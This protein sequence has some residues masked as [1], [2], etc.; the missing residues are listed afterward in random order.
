MKNRLFIPVLFSVLLA[1]V[2]S[3]RLHAEEQD[4]NDFISQIQTS[5]THKDIAAYLENFARDI[6]SSEE[7]SFKDKFDIFKMERASLFKTGESVQSEDNAEVFLQALFQNSYSAL[8]ETWHLKL[9]RMNDQWQITDK[10]VAGNISS[11]YRIQIPSNSAERVESVEVEHEDIKLTFKDAWLFSDNIPNLET[12][13]LIIGKGN[14]YFSPSDPIEKHQLKL[15]Y[16]KEF[17]DDKLTYAFLRFS[18]SYFHNHIKIER[19]PEW[20][21]AKPSQEDRDAAQSIFSKHYPRSFTVEYSLNREL[22]STLPQ[23][24][25]AV[26]DFRGEKHGTFTYVYSPFTDE[27]INLYRWKD[28]QIINLYSPKS[29]G[30]QKELFLSFGQMFEV[31]SYQIEVDFRPEQYFLSGK[32]RIEVESYVESL[33]KLKFKLNP[34]LNILRIQ[35]EEGRTLFYSQDKLRETLYVYFIHSPPKNKPYSI[36]VFY[37][38]K[39]M[40]PV[41]ISDA[42]ADPQIIRRGDPGRKLSVIDVKYETYL[43]SQRASWYPSPAESDY[44]QARVKI[45]VPAEFQCISNGEMIETFFLNKTERVRE[46]DE[47]ENAVFIFDVKYPVKYLSM[48]IGKFTNVEEDH[49]SLPLQHFYSSGVLFEKK[50]LLREAKNIVEFFEEK[51]GAYPYEKLDIVRRLWTTYGGHSPAS[52]IIINELFQTPDGPL[53]VPVRSPVDLSRW[54][55]YFIA[56][57]ISHQWWGQAV[58]WKTYHDLWLSEGLA[59][60]SA[61]LYLSE[62]HGKEVLEPIFGKFTHWTEKMTK[63]GPVSLGARLAL[64]DPMAFQTVVYNK[65]A[66]A[67]NMLKDLLGEEMF[68]DGLNRFYLRHK[69]GRASTADFI[70]AMEDASGKSLRTFFKNWFGS[71]TLPGVKVSHSLHKSSNGYILK[72]KIDQMKDVFVFPLWIEWRENGNSV[73]RMVVVDERNEEFD[74]ELRVKPQKIEVNPDN[75]VPGKFH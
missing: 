71:Y 64:H 19:S 31:K 54:R 22:F 72:F 3:P 46:E 67:L 14:L 70:K 6:R 65:A 41:E 24:D 27:E 35:D 29:D 51:F 18:N 40:P 66:L 10:N 74:I 8:I 5:L 55:E 68:F 32:A 52:F 43:F 38:G 20:K 57:E 12:A 7:K 44:F 62:K 37:R 15:S 25:E 13:L 53:L 17:L 33:E 2:L 48:I 28:K 58:T 30:K 9:L 16:K 11:L 63:W 75:A 49:G 34:K 26:F 60:F 73:R 47:A 21:D 23:G 50:G 36:D 39:L 69:F 4:L 61:V 59:Q 42:V 56:H 45:S 1:F